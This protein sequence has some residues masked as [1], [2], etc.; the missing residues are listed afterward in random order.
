MALSCALEPVS[1][2]M[3]AEHAQLIV[4]DCFT[5][6]VIDIWHF[7]Y[8]FSAAR[9]MSKSVSFL[10][11]FLYFFLR[12]ASKLLFS[13]IPLKSVTIRFYSDETE[14]T[15]SISATRMFTFWLSLLFQRDIQ[16]KPTHI[17]TDEKSSS[18][19][20]KKKVN[21]NALWRN[22]WTY[23]PIFF[24][25]CCLFLIFIHFFSPLFMFEVKRWTK[26]ERHSETWTNKQKNDKKF[27]GFLYFFVCCSLFFFISLMLCLYHF[28]SLQVKL[29]HGN[30]KLKRN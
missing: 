12:K 17:S 29:S 25:S 9:P 22:A 6:Y 23:S 19:T 4:W 30:V 26:N 24:Q 5:T 14:V 13:K 20:K 2:F 7:C 16:E 15:N 1:P 27:N 3:V 28:S 10:T 8:F 18:T 11:D 21:S